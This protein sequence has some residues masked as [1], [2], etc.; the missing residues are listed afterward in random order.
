MENILNIHNDFS[1]L[2]TPSQD[3]RRLLC[4]KLR[5]RQKNYYHSRAYQNGT[6][7]G[8]ISFFQEKTGR[9]LTGLLPEVEF[10]LTKFGIPYTIKDDRLGFNFLHKSIDANFLNQW[11]P[12]GE[13]PLILH[14]YQVELVNKAIKNMRGIVK[15]PTASGKAQPLDSVV[16]TPDGPKKMGEINLGDIICTPDGKTAPVIGVFPQG[17]KE[18]YKITFSNGDTVECCKE[19]LWKI[20]SI[21]ND[22]R[23]KIKSTEYLIHHM[24][25]KAGQPNLRIKPPEVTFFNTRF[26]KIDPYLMG[27]LLGDGNLGKCHIKLTNTNKYLITTIQNGLREDYHLNRNGTSDDWSLV[28]KVRGLKENIYLNAIRE[29]NLDGHRSWEK[30]IPEDF[31]YN[32][33][34]NRMELI[35]GILNTDGYVDEDG[36]TS[37]TTT[38]QQL[39]KDFKEVIESLGGMCRT[40]TYLKKYKY[41]GV[42]KVGRLAYTVTFYFPDPTSL[43]NIEFKKSRCRVQKRP[44]KNR[45][46]TNIQQVGIKE[47]QCI[48][49]DHPDHLYLTDNFVPTHN[50]EIMI[51]IMK[52]MPVGTP[53]LFLVNRKSLVVQNYKKMQ[54]WGFNKVGQFYGEVHEP[55]IITC[56]TVQSLKYLDRLLPHFKALIVDEIH[57]MSNTSGIKAF[58]K[59]KGCE[60]RIAV[61][62][63]PFKF[64]DKDQVQKYTVKGYFGPILTT[65][66]LLTTNS[67]QERGT[68]S[69]SICTFYPIEEPLLPYELY[70]DAVTYG[71]A[72][73]Y[74]FHKIVSKLALGLKGRTLIL[75]ERLAH[76]DALNNL[77]PGSLWVRGQDNQETREHVIKQLTSSS[78]TVAIATKGIFDAGLNFFAHN[79]INA[80][81]GKAEHEIVQRIGRGLRTAD[82]KDILKYYDFIFK[83]NPYL[84]D[85]SNQR[86]KILKKEKHEV[87]IKN[88]IDF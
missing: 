69:D 52:A 3:I 87:V 31:K 11:T 13:K 58:K 47:C 70:I 6:W 78:Y 51:A 65:E 33:E 50:T 81:G 73:N 59:L 16:W 22:W 35:R 85:H 72:N 39:A 21:R 46:I 43:C 49:V 56:A 25:D 75:V 38:S 4:E 18:V 14:D 28:K 19:H 34:E 61:S 82:D 48:L 76:G 29:Y 27:V 62:A 37:L 64:G 8:F 83:I 40:K 63:T 86:I 24:R 7:N 15:A 79:L 60:V 32:S 42:K 2:S 30:F 84:E 45:V 20:D 53:T 17:E 66:K 71:I 26:L 44:F 74:A 1:Y 23:D 67:L 77:I 12:K 10:A 36:S 57:M 54:K 80:A 41:K 5:F 55:N 68:I 9:F 88:K